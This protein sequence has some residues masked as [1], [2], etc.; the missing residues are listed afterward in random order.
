M[1]YK[2]QIKDAQGRYFWTL[3]KNRR[4]LH[5][6]QLMVKVVTSLNINALCDLSSIEMTEMWEFTDNEWK[7]HLAQR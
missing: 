7:R 2:V 3:I 5:T 4:K 6:N 1:V